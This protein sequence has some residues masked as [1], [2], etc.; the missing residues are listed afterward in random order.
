MDNSFPQHPRQAVW[1]LAVTGAHLWHG[2][3]TE[4]DLGEGG[5]SLC[6]PPRTVGMPLR[7]RRTA[8]SLV[9]SLSQADGPRVKAPPTLRVDLPT[10]VGTMQSLRRA[11]PPQGTLSVS[12]FVGL[13]TFEWAR[14]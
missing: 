1:T 11:Y 8:G 10:Q 3:V 12:C 14:L 5:L 9:C 13:C 7:P 6:S 2:G 4:A